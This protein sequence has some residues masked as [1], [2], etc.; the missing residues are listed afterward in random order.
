MSKLTKILIFILVVIFVAYLGVN[1]YGQYQSN[2]KYDKTAE[3]F[4]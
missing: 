3:E 4:E 1:V 2:I